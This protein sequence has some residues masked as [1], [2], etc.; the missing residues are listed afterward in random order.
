MHASQSPVPLP[1]YRC[2]KV[3]EAAEI[4]GV[5]LIAGRGAVLQLHLGTTM[6]SRGV[7]T[8]HCVEVEVGRDWCD[9]HKVQPGGYFVRYADG[10][11]SFSPAAAFEEG[12]APEPRVSF[13]GTAVDTMSDAQS[14]ALFDI[15]MAVEKIDDGRSG[16]L[17]NLA[18]R[19][20]RIGDRL[21]HA[22]RE[23]PPT[24]AE[25]EGF[26]AVAHDPGMWSQAADEYFVRKRIYRDHCPTPW[27][28]M[29]WRHGPGVSN[30]MVP[31]RQCEAGSGS[32]A[33]GMMPV[34]PIGGPLY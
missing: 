8:D 21:E 13:S 15:S 11:T 7:E 19:I 5:T 6:V 3:V 4:R 34:I 18:P 25:S 30:L 28:G 29:L 12:Y 14:K 17:E 23:A 32:E 26:L 2:H 27:V 10:Y 24:A 31:K 1:R 9:H 20:K 33:K 16:T 22:E